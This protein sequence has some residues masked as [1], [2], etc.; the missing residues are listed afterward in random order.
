[1]NLGPV[2]HTLARVQGPRLN[3]LQYVSSR[4]RGPSVLVIQLRVQITDLPLMWD[5][6]STLQKSVG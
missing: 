5:A 1:M 3:M 6:G 4:W 2:Y